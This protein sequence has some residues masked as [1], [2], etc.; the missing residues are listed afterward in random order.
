MP[1]DPA[2]AARPPIAARM[3]SLIY[4]VLGTLWW[5]LALV[6]GFVSS[7]AIWVAVG[8]FIGAYLVLVAVRQADDERIEDLGDRRR[9]WWRIVIAT[10]LATGLVVTIGLAVDR[11]QLILPLAAVIF[12]QHFIPLALVLDW[13]PFRTMGLAATAA[14]IGGI[15]AAV[16]SGPGAAALVA[17]GLVGLVCWAGSMGLASRSAGFDS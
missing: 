5:L 7:T 10:M 16:L 17:E 2:E 9:L 12:G 11:P 6:G 13:A 8:F 15:A 14:G 4:A 1:A 3:N